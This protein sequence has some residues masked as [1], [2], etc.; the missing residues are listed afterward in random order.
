MEDKPLDSNELEGRCET[1][2]SHKLCLT[3][4]EILVTMYQSM[5]VPLSG[6]EPH[7]LPPLALHHHLPRPLK[8]LLL[9]PE[10]R[11]RLLRRLH[12]RRVVLA[13]VVNGTAARYMF[14]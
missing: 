4:R 6:C 12:G 3:F 8:V 5:R 14:N 10:H 9:L 11:R 13:T 2:N 7:A 1:V